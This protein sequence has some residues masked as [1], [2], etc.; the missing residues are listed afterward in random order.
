[1]KKSYINWKIGL[2][3][4]LI[5][6]NTNMVSG[7]DS[8]TQDISITVE[9]INEI[10]VSSGTVD[11]VINAA[12]AGVVAGDNLYS[13]SDSSTT[14][15]YSTNE[16]GKK[17]SAELDSKFDDVMLEVE[18]TSTSGSSEGK[19]GLTINPVDVITGIGNTSDKDE[20]I[21]YTAS[22][23][24]NTPPTSG[25]VNTVTFTLTDS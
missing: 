6:F 5:F 24:S 21:T 4:I 9:P 16:S 1:M 11:M 25:E 14:L 15:S 8:A 7:E 2:I 3:L 19:V 12:N 13:V 17:I 18:L 20:I 10:S 22:A 23:V